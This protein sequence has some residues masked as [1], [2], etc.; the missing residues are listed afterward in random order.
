MHRLALL[1]GC[2]GRR[3]SLLRFR[4]I[5]SRRSDRNSIRHHPTGRREL[6]DRAGFKKLESVPVDSD[7]TSSM[8][9]RNSCRFA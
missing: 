7:S 3:T 8:L 2:L 9:C 6:L 4:N 5:V 1:V